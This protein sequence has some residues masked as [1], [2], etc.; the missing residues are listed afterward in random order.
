MEWTWRDRAKAGGCHDFGNLV[1][2]QVNGRLEKIRREGRLATGARSSTSWPGGREEEGD[3]TGSSGKR[4]RDEALK[5]EEGVSQ[6][7]DR[8]AGG[9]RLPCDRVFWAK[10][11]RGSFDEAGC[12][13][14]LLPVGRTRALLC[15]VVLTRR[16]TEWVV[17]RV[18]CRCDTS[19]RG[20][21]GR[22]LVC[23]NVK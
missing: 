20:G 22:W 18:D 3:R 19:E 14:C 16:R 5:R 2:H 9:R 6:Q 15:G 17:N 11:G 13:S 7:G 4:W 10:W 23:R 12:C 1:C 21:C 8:Q